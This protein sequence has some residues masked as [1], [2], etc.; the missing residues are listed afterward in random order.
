MLGAFSGTENSTIRIFDSYA[1]Y[2]T[3]CKK[4]REGQQSEPFAVEHFPARR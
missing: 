3:L 2:R 1:Q 4:G